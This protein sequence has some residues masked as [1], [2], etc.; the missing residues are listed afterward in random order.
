MR[1]A[2]VDLDRL[3]RNRVNHD[4][5]VGEFTSIERGERRMARPR[6]EPAEI[7]VS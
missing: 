5:H 2:G 7:V 4:L 3:Q 1:V 6:R